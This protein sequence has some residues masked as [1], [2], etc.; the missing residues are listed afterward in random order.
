MNINGN[1]V[2]DRFQI[3]G[4]FMQ[5]G[6]FSAMKHKIASNIDLISENFWYEIVREQE[7]KS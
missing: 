6:L 7:I 1:E 4:T 2:L 3:P 5:K